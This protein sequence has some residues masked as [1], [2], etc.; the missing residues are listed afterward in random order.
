MKD[1]T[2][3]QA[4]KILSVFE[5]LSL[6]QVQAIVGSGLLTDIRDCDI[7]KVNRDEARKVF[8]LEPLTLKLEPLLELL[9]TVT[10][11]ATTGKFVAKDR[12]KVN[13]GK[14]APVKI[15]WLGENLKAWFLNKEEELISETML[16]Y[17]ELRKPSV[18]GP[19]IAE[20]GDEAKVETTLAEMF[21]LME[22]QRNGKSG[23]SSH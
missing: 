22:R 11:P 23:G 5:D 21:A 7:S 6:E 14:N 3:R 17:H 4:E 20:L 10:I 18:D 12:L 2:L 9:G 16:R 13:T 1:A 15:S 8:G 19:I